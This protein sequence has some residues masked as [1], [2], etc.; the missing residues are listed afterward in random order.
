MSNTTPNTVKNQLLIRDQNIKDYFQDES[1][2][3]LESQPS[4][5]KNLWEELI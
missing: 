1:M 3:F 4:I 5:V 2:I